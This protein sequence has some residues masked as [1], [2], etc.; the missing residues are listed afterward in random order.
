MILTA[1]VDHYERLLGRNDGS[2]PPYGYTDERIAHVL[3]IAPDGAFVDVQDRL[4]P[5]ARTPVGRTMTVPAAAKRSGTLPRPFYLWDKSSYV[6]GVSRDE[7]KQLVRTPGH[8]EAFRRV[9]EALSTSPP[10]EGLVALQAF[11]RSWTPDRFLEAPFREDMLERNFA[12]RLDGAQEYLHERPALRR[13]WS[14]LYRTEGAPEAMCLVTGSTG[15]L[16]VIHPSIKGVDDAQSSGASIVS[17]NQDSFASFGKDQ[18]ANAPVS[19]GAAFAYTAVLNRLLR[20]SPDNRQRLRI[21][22]ATVVFWAATSDP[23][24]ADAAEDLVASFFDPPSDD[25][26]EAM[27]IRSVLERVRKGE[28]IE[29]VDPRLDS[30]TAMYVLGLAPNAARLSVRYWVTGS[31][32]TFAVRLAVHHADLALEPVPWT[33]PPGV[34]RVSHA[35]GRVIP[36]RKGADDVPHNLAGELVRSILT[37][38]RYPR[39]MLS[40]VVMRM[41]SDREVSG[42]RAAICKAVLNRDFRLGVRAIEKEI[43]V[44]LDPT[45]KTPGYVLG[46]LFA[47][48]EEIQQA[49]LGR[50]INATAYFSP[51]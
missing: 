37:G 1:L 3:V 42:L 12:F 51:S 50:D 13:L 21:G 19:E 31:L 14:S 44:S 45:L 5:F 20:R 39:S 41:R 22:D 2:V 27:R 33:R 38:E 36:G 6:L 35:A 49:A 17:F 40:A 29:D 10:D 28:P 23:A 7:G 47:T 46:R 16:A 11:L 25:E 26:Q 9:H 32:G 30:G 15:P 8:R 18:G 48:L 43:P 34:S 4:D 24:K